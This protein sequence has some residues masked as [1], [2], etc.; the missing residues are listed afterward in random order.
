MNQKMSWT[1][2]TIGTG[3]W[4]YQLAEVLSRHSDWQELT[5]PA[6]VSEV[7][8]AAAATVVA[9]AGALGIRWPSQGA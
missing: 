7:M 4:L 3:V 6:G 8:I 9:I 2:L 5:T 1:L